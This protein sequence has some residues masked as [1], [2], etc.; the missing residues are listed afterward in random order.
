MKKI[1]LFT[2]ALLATIVAS[3]AID[4]QYDFEKGVPGFMTI[5]GDAILEHSGDKFKDGAK[6]IKLSWN[7][8]AEVVFKNHY[9]ISKSMKVNGTGLMMWVYNVTPMADPVKVTIQDWK[10]SEICHFYFNANFTGWRAIWIKYV[11]MLTEDGHYGDKR[12]R[13]RNVDASYMTIKI[14]ESASAGTM[15][16]DR[17]TF[18]TT[19]LSDQIVP[20]MQIPENNW[21]LAKNMWQ[22][23]RLWEWEQYP[24]PDFKEITQREEDMLKKVEERLDKWAERGNSSANYVKSTLMPRVD[25]YFTKFHIR[26]LEDGTITGAPLLYDDECNATRG[27]MKLKHLQEIVYWSALDYIY[28][29]NES[30]VPRVI[31]AMDHAIDQGFAYGSGMGT[32]HHYAYH[33]RDIYKGVWI[34]RKPLA[35]AGKLDEYVKVLSYWS[36][37]QETR[38]P[39]DQARD[40][41][42]DAWNTLNNPKVISAML[43]PSDEQK[44]AYMKALGSWVS[45]SLAYS[46]GTS[47]GIKIDGTSFHHGGH[48]P[49]YSTGAFGAIGD[50]CWFSE[51]TDFVISESARKV[52]KHALL[53]MDDYT[54]HIDWGIGMCGRHPFNGRITKPDILAF[55]RLAKL[56]DLTGNG[57]NVDHDLAGAYLALGGDD[58]DLVS[59][60]KSDGVKPK[61]P[62]AGFRVY[63]YG[64]F[65]IHRRDDWM[66]TLKA[67]NS[68]GWGSEIYS[69]NNRYGRYQSYA[70][71]QFISADGA[72]KSGYTWEGWD[73]NRYPGVTS[74]HLPFELLDSPIRGTLMERNDARFPGVSSLEGMNG[75]L[76]F[77]HVEKDRKNFCAGA[78]VTASVFCFDNRIIHIGTGITNTSSYPTQTTLYQLRL[79]DS[80]DA[81]KVAKESTDDF[82]YIYQHQK[83]GQ[84]SLTDTKGNAYIVKNGAGLVVEKKIQSTPTDNRKDIGEGMFITAYIDHGASPS[85]ASYEY[86]MLVQPNS[87]EVSKYAKALPYSVLQA[88]NSAHVVT[89][90]ITGITAYISYKGYVSESTLVSEMPAE[91]IVME[92][93]KTEGDV[94]MSVCTP[95]LGLE[96][97]GYST[98]QPSQPLTKLIKLNGEWTLKTD[99]ANVSIS[100]D[101]GD[102]NISAV[103][104][105]GQPVEFELTRILKAE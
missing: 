16:F 60:F 73:W 30:N 49:Q 13:D 78:T 75:C 22:W 26:R 12:L 4:A 17:M 67:F 44:Y 74:I 96:V 79:E 20:D 42:L 46:D 81:V 103:C 58:R 95:D 25:N 101:G 71:V 88:D 31:D 77:T 69:A 86:M 7:G 59:D 85:E 14:P 40:G 18:S 45:G 92:R 104:I 57:H 70:S 98:D 5:K 66:L 97:K 47:G 3:A 68:D 34:L 35:E 6:S 63:N 39:C 2:I 87:K 23:C 38:R 41:V 48:Y 82:P 37:L 64:G 62:E 54:N 56:G 102:T 33:I 61:T 55:G 32:N 83:A 100:Q 51:G 15:Y 80:F 105:H 43:L 24:E 72:L 90:Q 1:L 27:E 84:V 36:G 10:N 76:A 65:G 53:A 91:V 19:K 9:D 94:V 52:F 11:D 99:V 8:P 50:F 29:G 28:T 89:D 93:S 21:S